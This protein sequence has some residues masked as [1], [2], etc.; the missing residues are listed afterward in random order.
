MKTIELDDEVYD[1]IRSK[2]ILYEDKTEN[3]TVRRLFGFGKKAIPQ[4]PMPPPQ[5][6][7]PMIVGQKKPKA[8]LVKL[9][10]AGVLKEG[11]ILHMRY[12]GGKIADSEA[13]IHQKGLLKD[14]EK[15]SMSNLAGKFLKKQGS[16]AYSFRG[17]IYWFTSD[18]ISV[19]SLW[20]E[21]LKNSQGGKPAVL[22][23]EINLADFN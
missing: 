23:T 6:K 22:L 4:Q 7:F 12:Q 5:E 19:E 2:G 21:Y 20:A 13:T 11:Q 16:T 10:N 15:Y 3:D 8:S 14:G 18:N 1:Y 9:V 17:P